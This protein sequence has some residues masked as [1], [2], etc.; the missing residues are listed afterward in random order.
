M[1]KRHQE[2]KF[3]L[4]MPTDTVAKMDFIAAYHGRSRNSEINWANR[5][6]IK[7]F[8]KEHGKIDLEMNPSPP[9]EKV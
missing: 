8:E 7:A 2:T 3:T 9:L 4:R 5:C 6:Y 1:F